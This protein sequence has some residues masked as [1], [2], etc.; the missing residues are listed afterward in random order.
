MM[1]K[2]LMAAVLGTFAFCW[3]SSFATAQQDQEPS[4]N[5][6]SLLLHQK[7][8]AGSVP[9]AAIPPISPGEGYATIGYSIGTIAQR[10]NLT[11][12]IE[13]LAQSLPATIGNSDGT[14]VVTLR[15][16]ASGFGIP[17]LSTNR[18]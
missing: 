6:L 13:Y 16:K 15:I 9:S 11:K 18:K 12:W 4:G 10:S 14:Y 7:S 1:R 3:Y 8:E 2:S 5:A 17:V